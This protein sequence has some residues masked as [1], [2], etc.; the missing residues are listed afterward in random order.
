MLF[1]FVPGAI[2]LVPLS[3]K[4]SIRL[5]GPVYMEVGDAR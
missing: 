4:V 1:I 3:V 2:M 5:L